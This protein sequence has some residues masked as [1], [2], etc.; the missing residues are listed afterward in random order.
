MKTHQ[1]IQ[2]ALYLFKKSSRVGEN[3][4]LPA[5][6]TKS[7]LRRNTKASAL[8]ALFYGITV[9]K[10]YI[11][12]E[13]NVP[14]LLSYAARI[15]QLMQQQQRTF[16]FTEVWIWFCVCLPQAHTHTGTTSSSTAHTWLWKLTS[17]TMKCA[18]WWKTSKKPRRQSSFC[19][20]LDTHQ[21]WAEMQ[22]LKADVGIFWQQKPT[23]FNGV[24]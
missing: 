14:K 6:T 1:S 17:F 5:P 2:W 21:P 4:L 23:G 8:W 9:G 20:P 13:S 3:V 12:W 16:I 11:I 10:L 24:Y 18:K 22:I 15:S 7:T 19:V